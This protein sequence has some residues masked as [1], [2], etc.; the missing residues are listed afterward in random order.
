MLARLAEYGRELDLH[1]MISLDDLIY[2]HRQLRAHY[3][4]DRKV[5]FQE[6]ENARAAGRAQGLEQVT[7]GEY[8]SV[9]ALRKMTVAELASFI[10]ERD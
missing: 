5:W 1:G 9:E 8:I 6:L 4:A 10:G 7:Q 2:S 3:I